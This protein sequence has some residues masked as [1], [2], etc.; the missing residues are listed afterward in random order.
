MPAWITINIA[1]IKI[2]ANIMRRRTKKRENIHEFNI[3]H[4][5]DKKEKAKYVVNIVK[6]SIISM[7]LP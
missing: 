4:L 3:H 1:V 7:K 2:R 5:G 6:K